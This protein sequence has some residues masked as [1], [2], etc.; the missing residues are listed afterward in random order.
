[1]SRAVSRSPVPSAGR[2]A[3]TFP[4]S[5]R[6]SLLAGSTTLRG[7]VRLHSTTTAS[8]LWAEG[9][10][11]STLPEAVTRVTLTA[12]I[13]QGMPDGRATGSGEVDVGTAGR[14]RAAT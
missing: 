1:M 2:M 6:S 11:R 13:D 10:V 14:T 7:T 4:Q 8:K 9:S 12:A 5:G 3:V